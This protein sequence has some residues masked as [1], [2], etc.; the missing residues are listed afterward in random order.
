VD[1]DRLNRW[2]TLIAN[3]AVIAGII[4]LAV[5]IRV[6]SSAIQSATIQA[7]TDAS[8]ES[9]RS[10]SADPEM[11]QLRLNGD[12]NLED[13]SELQAYQYHVYYRQHWL[14]FQNIYFQRDFGVLAEGIWSTYAKIICNDITTEGIRATWPNH[15]VVLDPEFV[16]FVDAC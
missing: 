11:A 1:Q 12:K 15:A 7:I 13:L 2:L 10:L 14:R 4:F 16:K 8:A 9:L 6:N 3:V 5:E